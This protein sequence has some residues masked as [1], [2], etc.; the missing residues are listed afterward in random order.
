MGWPQARARAHTHPTTNAEF[1]M[2]EAKHR[3][4]KH[5]NKPA[6]WLTLQYSRC[7]RN[8]AHA[9]LI[10]GVYIYKARGTDGV[11]LL[12]EVSFPQSIGL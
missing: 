9:V 1:K 3:T 7:P 11:I 2:C 12:Y 4:R 5:R 10:I 6:A 8:M